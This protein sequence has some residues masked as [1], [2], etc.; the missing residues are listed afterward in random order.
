MKKL[1]CLFVLFCVIL[2]VGCAVESAPTVET[3][4]QDTTQ[5]TTEPTTE[6]TEPTT[7]PTE[8][9]EEP[10]KMASYVVEYTSVKMQRDSVGN[11]WLNVIV[12]VKNTGEE[13]IRLT[14]GTIAAFADDEQV[15]LI[16]NATCYPNILRPGEIG[17]YFEQDP[18]YVEDGRELRVEFGANM[19]RASA[20][21][22]QFIVEDSQVYD[23]AFGV[24]V[25][26]AFSE[27]VQG[28]VC[29]AVLFDMEQKPFAVLYE[30][31]DEMTNE[32]TLSSDKLPEGLSKE[33]VASHIVYV[34]RYE[35]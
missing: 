2:S 9:N 12:T 34:Y 14:D 21:N 5:P 24:E 6:A 25:R 7:L 23:A 31:F 3:F 15:L 13:A 4:E 17:Y 10:P 1:L 28:I 26:G 19:E 35:S 30:Y 29:A 33:D 16:E 11:S 22:A 27:S 18:T 32:F 20:D 8:N